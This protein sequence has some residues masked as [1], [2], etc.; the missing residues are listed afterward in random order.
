MC[1][2][3]E[4]FNYVV[5]KTYPLRSLNEF[6]DGIKS[7]NT[8]YETKFEVLID[9]LYDMQ[10]GIVC[11]A[12]SKRV[13]PC[14]EN[15]ESCCGSDNCCT[16]VGYIA[17]FA[18]IPDLLF[19]SSSLAVYGCS[20]CISRKADQYD[21]IWRELYKTEAGMRQCMLKAHD[22]YRKHKRIIVMTI[23]DHFK[24]YDL[25]MEQNLAAFQDKT[26][27][28]AKMIDQ[29]CQPPTLQLMN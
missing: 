8:T 25:I 2:W 7:M 29:H 16:C 12:G 5:G 21:V 10:Q 24:Q 27:Y 18:W 4:F 13:M 22:D 17:A 19:C 28:M 15:F 6:M 3:L 1:A 20:T 23:E 9:A 11:K 26:N 14:L